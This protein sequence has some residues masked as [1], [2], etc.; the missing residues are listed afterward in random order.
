MKRLLAGIFWGTAPFLVAAAAF[1]IAV[2]TTG[3]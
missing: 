3:N 1:T 2:L